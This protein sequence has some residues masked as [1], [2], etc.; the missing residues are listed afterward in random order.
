MSKDE[1]ITEKDIEKILEY[2]NE[3]TDEM[4]KEMSKI[5]TKFNLNNISLT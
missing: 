1:A 3:K 4:N 5:D 2:G